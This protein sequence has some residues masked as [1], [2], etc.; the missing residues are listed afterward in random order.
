MCGG[1]VGSVGK[2]RRRSSHFGAR[3]VQID[4]LR[5]GEEA[6]SGSEDGG[7]D[8]T[9]RR[10]GS[11]RSRSI[12]VWTSAELRAWK[13][14]RPIL[15]TGRPGA[16]TPD[17]LLDL[18][19]RPDGP[20][21][22]A[23]LWHL[24]V[25]ETGLLT[26]NLHRMVLAAQGLSDLRYRPGQ[27]LMLRVP[28]PGGRV[29]NRRY[30]IRK[31]DPARSAVALDVSLH[32]A[33]PGT[34][35]VRTAP[36]GSRIDAIGPRGKISL[37]DGAAWHLFVGDETGL[38]G[39]LAMVESLAPVSVAMALLEIDAPVDEQMPESNRSQQLD[40]RWLHRLGHS[41]PGDP[42]LLVE[43][44]SNVDLP[45]G[46]GHVYVAAEARVVRAIQQA[47][48]ERGLTPDQISAKAYWRRGLPNAEHGEP[49]RE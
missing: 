38:P 49:T 13:V 2:E 8:K 20:L 18:V 41:A 39:I 17:R 10:Y 37:R 45:D 40:L 11:T 19:G 28:Q 22:D 12:R 27:D 4:L 14:H 6:F 7:E 48:T 9:S 33:G 21:A 30:T 24:E 5:P 25:I 35:W 16:M 42:S 43:G 34:D 1:S 23:S 47:L 15:A 26:P 44:V 36:V 31:F 32:G 29:I 46:I 3:E